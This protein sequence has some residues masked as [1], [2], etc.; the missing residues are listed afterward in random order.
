M[1]RW[2]RNI[3]NWVGGSAVAMDGSVKSTEGREEGRAEERVEEARKLK[4]MG[5]P[6][7]T[8]MGATCLS[9]GETA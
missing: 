5:V 7:D 9:C 2:Y 4:G 6:T 3:R 1:L 8:I